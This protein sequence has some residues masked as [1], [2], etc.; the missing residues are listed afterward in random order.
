[1]ILITRNRTSIHVLLGALIY[2]YRCFIS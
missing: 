2:G 1:M